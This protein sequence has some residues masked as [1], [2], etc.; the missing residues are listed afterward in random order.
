MR[1]HARVGESQEGR[2]LVLTLDLID[3]HPIYNPNTGKRGQG[4][5]G[6][7][8]FQDAGAPSQPSPPPHP[9][10]SVPDPRPHHPSQPLAPPRTGS[11]SPALSRSP[12]EGTGTPPAALSSAPARALSPRT[13]PPGAGRG[14]QESGGARLL[15]C[16]RHSPSYANLGEVV[17]SIQPPRL[18]PRVCFR[19]VAGTGTNHP[20]GGGGWVSGVRERTGDVTGGDKFYRNK[21]SPDW[22]VPEGHGV[23]H[24]VA[25]EE[26]GTEGVSQGHH[27]S[28]HRK[29]L[30]E[31]EKVSLLA[32]TTSCQD[33]WLNNL[34][35]CTCRPWAGSHHPRDAPGCPLSLP[36]RG[37]EGLSPCSGP[38]VRSHLQ[39]LPPL[40][41]PG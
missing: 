12:S 23:V 5:K 10:P 4:R 27:S 6:G 41:R 2:D 13:S 33:T 7:E 40:S 17:Y 9:S 30:W 1:Q 11:A 8:G 26:K 31:L 20:G 22:Q 24:E 35:N 36:R 38:Q 25:W 34:H 21:A 18:L 32:D 39:V 29:P 28:I 19:P 15:G 16:P 3:R 14:A 37:P